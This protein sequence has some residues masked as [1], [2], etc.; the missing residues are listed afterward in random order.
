[1]NCKLFPGVSEVATIGGMVKQYQVVIDPDKLRGYYLTL[2]KVKQAIEESNQEVGGSV[3]E[4]SEAEYMVR[5]KGYLR[6]CG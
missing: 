5:F 1:M 4:L 6:G 3:L 2:G